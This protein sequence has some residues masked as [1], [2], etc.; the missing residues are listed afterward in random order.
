MTNLMIFIPVNEEIGN[1]AGIAQ[2]FGNI[3]DNCKDQRNYVRALGY[4]Q[5]A[6][7]I[8]ELLEDKDGIGTNLGAIGECFLAIAKDTSRQKFADSVISSDN[9]ININKSIDYLT[10]GISLSREVSDNA[11]LIDFSL[12]LSEAYSLAGN[13]PAA[14]ST[15]KSYIS[16]K[17]SVFSAENNLKIARL[18][19]QRENQLKEKVAAYERLQ[20]KIIVL[21]VVAGFIVM[22]VII[23]IVVKNNR[24][25]R[26]SNK[27]LA[28]E[29]EK[30]DNLLLNI[31]PA[32]VA[33]ELKETGSAEAKYFD[34]ITVLFTDFVGFTKVAGTM[35]PQEL[36]AELHSCFKAFDA[37]TAKYN[38]EK[39]K[40]IG[41]AY[42]AIAGLPA[43]N[44]NHAPDIVNAAIEIKRFMYERKQS[45]GDK[46]FEIRIGIHSGSVVAGIVGVRKFAYDIWGDSVN[47][48]ARMEQNSLPGK[49]N[50]SEATYL[51]VKHK[52]ECTYRGEIE[53]KNKGKLKMYF[54]VG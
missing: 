14:F 48:A 7:N 51:L 29:K 47:T 9:K 36:V 13:F 42:M 32:E 46:T 34:N 53:A 3:G 35:S 45:L 10:R 44:L 2:I 11:N 41:D 43:A 23:F 4:Y 8:Y 49:I 26:K 25:Q 12:A 28:L 21:S 5:K 33:E 6:L 24:A 17:D 52:I 20:Q 1:N 22:F 27:L 39:I 37:I 54:V 40:T 30:S 50:I 19:T 31:L 38:I 16:L 18:E 15:V